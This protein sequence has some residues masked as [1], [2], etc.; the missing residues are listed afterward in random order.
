MSVDRLVWVFDD[1][2]DA[3]PPVDPF[4]GGEVNFHDGPGNVHHFLVAFI[5]GHL[6]YQ[7]KRFCNQSSVEVR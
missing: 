4:D 3:V 7:A 1:I 5:P 6:R 2:F